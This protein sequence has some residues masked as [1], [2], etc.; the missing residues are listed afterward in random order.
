MKFTVEKTS[1]F[2]ALQKVQS[3]VPSRNTLQILSNAMLTAR[4]GVITISTTDLDISVK[5]NLE[6]IVAEPGTTTLP[7]RKLASI[8][9][10]LPDS[11]IEFS[12]TEDDIATL[13][14]GSSFFKILGLPAR[15]FPPI[16]QAEGSVCYKIGA[17]AFREMLRKTSYATSIDETR[18]VLTGVMLAFRDS[19]LTMVATDGRRLALVEHDIELPPETELEMVLPIKTAN[20]LSHLLGDEGELSIYFNAGQAIFV[21][22]GAVLT[23]KLIECKYPNYRQCI[24]SNFEEH[25]VLEREELLAAIRRVSLITTDKTNS[26]SLTFSDNQLVITTQTPEV[27]EARETVP[28]K[29]SGKEISV[30]FNPQYIMDPLRNIDSDEIFIEMSDKLSPALIKCDLPFVYV[31]MPLRSGN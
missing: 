19:K 11:S 8:V 30:V 31:L 24:P 22:D 5:C 13:Q 4:D 7:I 1:L 9:R 3:V 29:Y 21:I 10:E 28:I 23:T 26:T 27:G 25:V 17:G 14:C 20:E 12:N 18:R 15:D 2:E 6:A 16:P